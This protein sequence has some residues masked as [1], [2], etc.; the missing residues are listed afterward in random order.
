MHQQEALSHSIGSNPPSHQPLSAFTPFTIAP[1]SLTIFAV[2]GHPICITFMMLMSFL[3]CMMLTCLQWS[4]ASHQSTEHIMKW[5]KL[6]TFI[7]HGHQQFFCIEGIKTI[8]L[9]L[10]PF[11]AF[12]IRK[13]WCIGWDWHVQDVEVSEEQKGKPS[14]RAELYKVMAECTKLICS[15]SLVVFCIVSKDNKGLWRSC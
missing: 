2:K 15:A 8:P 11:T 10:T 7:G 3:V 6:L 13:V 14:N 1:F 5:I 4:R 9:S 12:W